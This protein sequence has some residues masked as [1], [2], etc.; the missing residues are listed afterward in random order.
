MTSERD[1][2]FL[3]FDRKNESLSFKDDDD[4]ED[5]ISFSASPSESSPEVSL[6]SLKEFLPD[7]VKMPINWINEGKLK[8]FKWTKETGSKNESALIILLVMFHNMN[9]YNGIVEL[10]YEELSIKTN[11]SKAM[12]SSGIDIL[13]SMNLIQ[14]KYGKRSVYKIIEFNI[15]EKWAK[16]P[17]KK[18]YVNESVKGFGN[19]KKRNKIELDALKLYFIFTSGRDRSENICWISYDKIIEKTGIKRENIKAA[20][21]LL[22]INSLIVVDQKRNEKNFIKNG[23]RIIGISDY[24]HSGTSGRGLHS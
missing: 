14:K 24:I 22:C 5:D 17:S 23:Y 16:L 18:M 7:W 12:L 20:I 19:F 8:D 10:T 4:S 1:D 11:L 21:S 9:N 2:P 13:C 15:S 3:F 6:N